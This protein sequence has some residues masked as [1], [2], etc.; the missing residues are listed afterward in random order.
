MTDK[1]DMLSFLENIKYKTKFTLPSDTNIVYRNILLVYAIIFAAWT[2]L[3]YKFHF[4]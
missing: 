1:V 2:A 3:V 4:A